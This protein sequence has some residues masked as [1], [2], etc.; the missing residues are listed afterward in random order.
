MKITATEAKKNFGKYLDIAAEG[1]EII[2]TKNNREYAK[3]TTAK[4]D[5]IEILNSWVGIV[6]EEDL[7]PK[8]VDDRLDHI[9]G[10]DR[11]DDEDDEDEEE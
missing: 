6:R 11:E 5:P 9:L 2:I 7:P 4:Q 3:L 10:R 1:E 8:G